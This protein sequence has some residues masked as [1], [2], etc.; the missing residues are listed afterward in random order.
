MENE[1]IELVNPKDKRKKIYFMANA[2]PMKS[3]GMDGEL[4]F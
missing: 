2:L 1:S 4:T 3:L